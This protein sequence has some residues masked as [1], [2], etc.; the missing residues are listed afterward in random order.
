M[1]SDVTMWTKN[2]SK[3]TRNAQIEIFSAVRSS[4]GF[5]W[6]GEWHSGSC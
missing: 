4:Q 2:V 6:W 5:E 1:T 3:T